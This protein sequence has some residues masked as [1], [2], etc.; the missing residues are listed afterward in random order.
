MIE[1]L[2][3]EANDL[4]DLKGRVGPFWMTRE[5][6]QLENAPQLYMLLLPQGQDWERKAAL[7]GLGR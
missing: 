7:A 4:Y 2:G 6:V 1:I 3:P 5:K